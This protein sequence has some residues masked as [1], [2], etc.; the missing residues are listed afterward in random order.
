MQKQYMETGL[1]WTLRWSHEQDEDEMIAYAG[2]LAA[3]F[4]SIFESITEPGKAG[5]KN[6]NKE[7]F[8]HSLMELVKAEV[9]E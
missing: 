7:N 4:S 1:Y 5:E 9:K 6:D 2:K 3:R 8:E